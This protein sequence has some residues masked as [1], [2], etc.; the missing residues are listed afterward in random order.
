MWELDYK[1]SWAPKNWCCWTVVLEKTL[2]CP[3]NCKEVKPV[4]PEGIQS[5]IFSGRTDV[6]AETPIL[7]VSDVKNELIGKDADAGNDW[8]WEEKGITEHKMV[9][10]HHQLN[11]HEFEQ[12]PGVGD[13]Q[14]NLACCSPWGRR[15]RHDWV[16]ELNWSILH[17]VVYMRPC[18][19]L[20][21]PHPL[22][23]PP[24]CSRKSVFYL[25]VSIAVL[26][27]GSS[28]PSF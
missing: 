28:A 26:Q 9:G 20:L 18:Y 23:P 3:L 11:G 1:E 15:V 13:G 24:T 14:G 2:E 5:W 21:S 22:L 16:N 27:I 7:W 6:E 19:S 17:M 10:W 12:A 8:R 4:H 25:C